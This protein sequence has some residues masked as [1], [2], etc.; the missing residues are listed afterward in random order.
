MENKPEKVTRPKSVKLD[1][2]L[3]KA[4][5]VLDAMNLL[6]IEPYL[7]NDKQ[8]SI[9]KT[10]VEKTDLYEDFSSSHGR[11]VITLP[12]HETQMDADAPKEE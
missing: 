1:K 6:R 5:K 4:F 10:L 3:G 2:L 9:L 7:T 11:E 8:S 12:Q